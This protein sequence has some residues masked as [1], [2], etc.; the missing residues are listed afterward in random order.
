MFF[1]TSRFLEGQEVLD[2]LKTYQTS[3]N[4][5]ERANAIADLHETFAP[6]LKS[7]FSQFQHVAHSDFDRDDL[8]NFINLT[9]IEEI[10][11]KK[12][13]LDNVGKVF[14]YI[15]ESLAHKINLNSVKHELGQTSTT[16]FPTEMRWVR[17]L[18]KFKELH[19][20]IPDVSR[21]EDIEEMA[22]L[23]ETK[24][25]ALVDFISSHGRGQIKSIHEQ[26][27]E[28]EQT[29]E[30]LDTLRSDAP[31]PDSIV[32]N[33]MVLKFF[34]DIFKRILTK[35]EFDA[36]MLRFHPHDPDAETP[37]Y[38]ELAKEMNVP[39]R[40]FRHLLDEAVKK[41]QT[42]P[43]LLKLKKQELTAKLNNQLL[44]IAKNAFD[45]VKVGNS[46]TLV[47]KNSESI[48]NEVINARIQN[49]SKA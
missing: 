19:H 27:G 22:R 46:Y 11:N 5:K 40:K 36:L 31:L 39:F 14:K 9:F 8:R 43:E 12:L 29:V 35:D 26:V 34:L 45:I 48:I 37:S 33:R 38:E 28:G 44:K 17:E 24:P 18:P 2:T 3:T 16:H 20:R 25:D 41:I 49:K 4:P 7:L 32:N 30:L 42:N 15:N 21:R 47:R 10:G 1:F 23:M 13:K 6:K